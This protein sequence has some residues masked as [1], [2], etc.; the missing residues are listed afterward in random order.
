LNA[1]GEWKAKEDRLQLVQ[2][3]GARDRAALEAADVESANKLRV[4]YFK[5]APNPWFES[6]TKLLRATHSDWAY[7]T[8]TAVHVDLVACATWR[9]WGDVS[10]NARGELVRNCHRHLI[11]TLGELPSDTVLLFDGK[12]AYKEV[13]GEEVGI[14]QNLGRFQDR[15][16]ESVDVRFQSGNVTIGDRSHK[17]VAWNYPANRLSSDARVSV[18][19][20]AREAV[21]A[22]AT[23]E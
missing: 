18:A 13:V 3:F 5:R 4:N 9:A 16:G 10:Q 6:L 20:A 14:L 15:D 7:T 23:N 2:D 12:T 11:R 17:F 22:N 1:A 21:G 8:G 19:S